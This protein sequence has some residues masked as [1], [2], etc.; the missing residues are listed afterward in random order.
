[1]HLK[2]VLSASLKFTSSRNCQTAA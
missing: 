2:R 1:M